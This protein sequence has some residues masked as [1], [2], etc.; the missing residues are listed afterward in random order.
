MSW[1][2]TVLLPSDTHRYLITSITAVTVPF[3]TC[4]H[5]NP[6]LDTLTRLGRL[7]NNELNGAENNYARLSPLPCIGLC[8][9]WG[10]ELPSFYIHS[11]YPAQHFLMMEVRHILENLDFDSV[12]LRPVASW[13]YEEFCFWDVTVCSLLKALRCFGRICHHILRLG[14]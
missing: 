11:F 3:L 13:P 9:P 6:R 7:N 14:E 8:V 2:W 5:N 10:W 1:T 4:R 12:I